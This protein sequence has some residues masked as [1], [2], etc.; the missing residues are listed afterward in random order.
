MLQMVRTLAQ[1]TIALD[2]MQENGDSPSDD[3][4]GNAGRGGGGSGAPG[5]ESDGNNGV[6]V[7][8][9]N[10]TEVQLDA[11]YHSILCSQQ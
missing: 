5:D 6:T 3:G 10:N 7:C 4:G 2:E 11:G 1:F 9:Q 8:P